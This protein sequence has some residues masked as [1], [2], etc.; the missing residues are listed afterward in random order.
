MI[1]HVS[2]FNTATGLIDESNRLINVTKCSINRDATDETSL[3]ESCSVSLDTTSFNEGWYAIDAL[4]DGTRSRLGVFYLS[5][6]EIEQE[7]DGSMVYTLAGTSVLQP[8]YNERVSAGW[9]VVK[10]DSGTNVIKKLLASCPVDIEVQPFTIAKT[11]TY[12]SNVTKLGACWSILRNAGMCMQIGGGDEINDVA[13]HVIPTPTDNQAIKTISLKSGELTGSVSVSDDEV[14]YE[15]QITGRPYNRVYVEL[16]TFGIQTYLTIASQSIDLSQ[17]L[18]CDET[19]K[20]Q[21][22][23][24][25]TDE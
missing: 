25:D 1:V 24:A 13:I 2:P 17:G 3:L 23:V 6:D 19:L 16:P 5:L 7:S 14:G 15:C 4:S 8:A 22:Y 18:V 20:E 9:S 12:S 11:Q 10:G 21:P